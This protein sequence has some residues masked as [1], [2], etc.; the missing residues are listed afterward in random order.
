MRFFR[1]GT[2]IALL[3]RFWEGAPAHVNAA[4]NRRLLYQ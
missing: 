3:P 2:V 1:G 4:Q